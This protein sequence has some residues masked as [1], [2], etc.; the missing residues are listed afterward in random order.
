[1][2]TGYLILHLMV[3]QTKNGTRLSKAGYDTKQAGLYHLYRLY[4]CVQTKEFREQ[5]KVIFKSFLRTVAEEVQ[6][7]NG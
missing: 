1:M 3:Y 4:S 2:P 7:G 5:F 6:N